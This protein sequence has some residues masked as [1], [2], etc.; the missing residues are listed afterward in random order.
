M[1][2]CGEWLDF[3]DIGAEETSLKAGE[4]LMEPRTRALMGSC[5]SA[6]STFFFVCLKL[7]PGDFLL[8]LQKSAPVN[9]SR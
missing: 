8:I 5:D 2:P 9:M 7:P 3:V 1:N 4:A 6:L